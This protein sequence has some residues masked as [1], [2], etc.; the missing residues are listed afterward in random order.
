M[1]DSLFLDSYGLF[2]I[3]FYFILFI[4]YLDKNNSISTVTYLLFL[5]LL[6]DRLNTD[7]SEF[8]KSILF[9]WCFFVLF[10]LYCLHE[11]FNKRIVLF[12]YV[13]I[14]VTLGIL[15]GDNNF[16]NEKT[17]Y[18]YFSLS[19]IF[20]SLYFMIFKNVYNTNVLLL[21]VSGVLLFVLYSVENPINHISL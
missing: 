11:Y 8:Y 10:I 12:V 21:V 17:Q 18:L 9:F 14:L 6:F 13:V 1:I 2:F 19:I 5:L 3:I 4:Y 7:D 15:L 16:T 20:L